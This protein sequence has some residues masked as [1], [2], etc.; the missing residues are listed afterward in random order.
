MPILDIQRRLHESGRIRIGEQVPT[1]KGKTRPARLDH[2]RFTSSDKRALE[3]LSGLY[4][5]MVQEWAGA[6][7]GQQWELHA[8][9]AEVDVMLLPAAMS[10]SQFYELWTGG[11]CQR[12]CDGARKLTDDSPCE[13]DPENREC[14]PHTRLSVLLTDLPG[15]GLWRLETQGYNAMEELSGSIEL[16]S[17]IVQATGKSILPARLRLE[18]RE[19]KTPNEATKHFSVPVLDLD[20]NLSALVEGVRPTH[21]LPPSP[22][23]PV[24]ELP[25]QS[26]SEQVAALESAPP[27]APRANSAERLRPTGRRARTVAEVANNAPTSPGPETITAATAKTNLIKFFESQGIGPLQAKECAIRAWGDRGSADI[28]KTAFKALL[29]EFDDGRPFD[30]DA[31]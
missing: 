13:C 16:A 4:G 7:I 14:K 6:P 29:A 19:K 12:R 9:T 3:V 27:P 31:A 10:L 20:V 21:A 11:G 23:T 30:G 2:F 26:V 24:P 18:Q 22:V 28:T 17:L 1:S 25:A 15:S 8:Q 5:G